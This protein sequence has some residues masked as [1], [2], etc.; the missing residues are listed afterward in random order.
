[1]GFDP[2]CVLVS[3]K[4]E[5]GWAS[6]LLRDSSALTFAPSLCP[7][8]CERCWAP[9]ECWFPDCF[10]T[11]FFKPCWAFS[12]FSKAGT[13]LELFS[14]FHTNV[15]MFKTS[16]KSWLSHASASRKCISFP[17]FLKVESDV[18]LWSSLSA[19]LPSCVSC[20]WAEM[21]ARGL[22]RDWIL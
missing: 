4:R 17:L 9:K 18:L 5:G 13:C 11:Q 20:R 19:V 22:F 21:V 6:L 7:V 14:L 12:P 8:L 10:T 2:G 1:M 3:L 15:P 16:L